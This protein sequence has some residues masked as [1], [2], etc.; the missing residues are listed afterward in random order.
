MTIFDIQL[1]EYKSRGYFK[2]GYKIYLIA[3]D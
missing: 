1:A 3:L 2:S